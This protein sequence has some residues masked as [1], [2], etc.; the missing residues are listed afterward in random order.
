MTIRLLTATAVALLI[1][2][3]ALADCNREIQGLK[4][5]VTRADTGASSAKS[6]LP[7][8][9]HQEQVLAGNQSGE[10]GAGNAGLG[11]VPVSPH[12]R[13]V[14]GAAKTAEAG[15]TAGQQPSELIAQASDMA[16]AGNEEGCMQKVA[17]VKDLLG[18]E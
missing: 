1:A 11:D 2:A 10:S 18:L 13:N 16:E 3:P 9:P 5:A 14:L 6:G 8:T 4:E 7:A 12:Q 17:E 15:A